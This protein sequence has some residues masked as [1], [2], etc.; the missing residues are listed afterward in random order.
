M[1]NISYYNLLY[2]ILKYGIIHILVFIIMSIHDYTLKLLEL[3]KLYNKKT[4]NKHIS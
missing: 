2:T 1:K 4:P 3:S